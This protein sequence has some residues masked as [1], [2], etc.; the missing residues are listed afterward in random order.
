MSKKHVVVSLSGGMDSSTLLL[1]CLKEY[2]SVT[3]ISFDYGQKHRV[4]LEKAQSLVNYLNGNVERTEQD[5]LG[6]ITVTGKNFNPIN[7]RQIQLN[8]LVDLLDSALVTGGEDV[9]EGHYAEDNMKATVVPNRN[10]IFAS[11][12]QAVA[13]SVANRTGETCDI[14]MGIHA[15]DHAIYPDCR[16]EFRDADDAAFRMGNWEAERVGYFTPYLEGDKFTILQDGE[17][18]C[19]ELGLGFDEVYK[20]TNTSYKP[21][22]WYSRPE[23]NAYEWYS[24][25][26]SASSVERVEA[27]IKLGRKDPAPYADE[28]GPVTWEHVVAE[29][30]KVLDNHNS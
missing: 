28:T 22:K 19:K 29:V 3:A 14:A 21:I 10:K 8:G 17:V 18:L 9:P 24:D 25:Y 6:T 27:F 15:G 5:Q 23:T 11:I 30:T 12:T 16:Q 13:L 20:R 2:D 7:Y 1:R 26:K 4:E